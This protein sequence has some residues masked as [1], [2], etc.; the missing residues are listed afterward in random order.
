M[1]QARKP[2]PATNLAAAQSG[3]RRAAL[4][5]LRDTLA[6]S[7]DECDANMH[8]QLAGQYRATLAEL[9]ALP[10]AEVVSKRDELRARRD[11]RAQDR[12][13]AARKAAPAG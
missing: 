7:M 4:V 9:A 1:A 6:R 8:A 3:D 2:V 13:P 5:A 12:R 11:A 10:A